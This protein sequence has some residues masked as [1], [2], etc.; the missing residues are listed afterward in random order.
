M[1]AGELVGG[2]PKIHRRVAFAFV[3]VEERFGEAEAHA[4][5]LHVQKEKRGNVE[6]LGTPIGERNEQRREVFPR[7][8]DLVERPVVP[9]VNLVIFVVVF[10]HRVILLLAGE[11]DLSLEILSQQL[12]CA[13]SIAHSLHVG[14]RRDPHNPRAR[15]LREIAVQELP[16]H[17]PRDQ[18]ACRTRSF[19][20]L[21]LHGFA[22]NVSF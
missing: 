21:S 1:L 22:G 3:E 5:P 16:R 11:L 9:L 14:M 18:I 12:Q 13:S 7:F 20:Q 17:D 10:V 8:C 2:L 19:L 6:T 4:Q 15:Q